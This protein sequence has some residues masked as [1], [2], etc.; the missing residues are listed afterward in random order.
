MNERRKMISCILALTVATG[1]ASSIPVFADTASTNTAAT[2][3]SHRLAGIDRYATAVAISQK[4]WG[5]SDTVILA[6][7]EDY[8]DALTSGPLAKKYD[9]PI[10]LTSKASINAATIAEIVR[11]QAKNIIIIGREGAV[12]LG[13]ANQL[14]KAG[15]SDVTRIGGINRYE[16]STLVAAKLNKPSAVVVVPG[17]DFPDA[18]SVSSIAS[19]L[20]YSII[21]SAKSGLSDS[22]KNYIATN[23]IKKAYIVG[24]TG[25]L[26]PAIE[27]QVTG[28][29]RLAGVNRYETNLAVLKAFEST[30]NYDN[31]FIATGNNFADALAGAALASKTSSPIILAGSSM[32]TNT[33]EYLASKENLNT[34]IL[35]LGGQA[36]ISDS[37]VKSAIDEKATIAVA[38]NYSSE[39]TYSDGDISGSVII[40]AAGIN[41]KNTTISGDLLIASTVG[42]GSV[43]LDNVTV[44]GK[45][46]INGG[47]VNSVE[48]HNMHS[49]SVELDKAT[50]ESVRVATDATSSIDT[51]LVSANG[52][53]DQTSASK[54]GSITVDNNSSVVLKGGFETVQVNGQ[55]STVK[56]V[57][58]SIATLYVNAKS[59]KT[60]VNVD[61]NSTVVNLNVNAAVTVSGTGSI[62][63]ANIGANGTTI[64]II[65]ANT[66][67][68]AG[69]STLVNG[70]TKDSTNSTVI[71]SV[72]DGGETPTPVTLA[73]SGASVINSTTVTFSSDVAP[74]TVT[75]NGK[76]TIAASYNAATKLETITV[77]SITSAE[78]ALVVNATGYTATTLNY[79]IPVGTYENLIVIGTIADLNAA[80]KAQADGQTWIINAGNYGLKPIN[81]YS[82]SSENQTG[83]YF[84]ITANNITIQGIGNPTLF[85]N[86]YTANGNWSTQNLI[87]IFGD[88][89]KISGLTLMNK[90]DGNKIIEVAGANSTIEDCIIKP[91]T[92]IDES[93]YDNITNAEDKEFAKQWGGSIYYNS[94]GNHVMKNVIINNSGISF[95]YSPAGTHINFENVNLIYNSNID[96]INSYKYSSGFNNSDCSIT[97]KPVVS[98]VVDKVDGF[99]KDRYEPTSFTFG[100]D[101]DILDAYKLGI[102]SKGS[103][104]ARDSSYTSNF[105][106]TQGKS[107]EVANTSKNTSWQVEAKIYIS[108]EMMAGEKPFRAELWLG[109]KNPTGDAV[110][111]YPIIGIGNVDKDN[112]YDSTN[113]A[114]IWRWWNSNGQGLWTNS[115][116]EGVAAPSKGWH[117]LKMKCNGDNKI[118]YYVDNIELAEYLYDE[119]GS[120]TYLS[121][122]M[123]QSYNYNNYEDYKVDGNKV[124]NYSFDAYFKDINYTID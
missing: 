1:M 103:S 63:N 82:A 117:T 116:N 56:V 7:G 45:I 86:E 30:F 3:A 14:T 104:I 25:V 98:Y 39:G 84:P 26:S 65:P 124:M 53:V 50:G 17:L 61:T 37:I 5:T 51:V 100:D 15:F 102:D 113:K 83:W 4:G 76:A 101:L 20:G 120:Q 62:T 99:V 66:S 77:P 46:I 19:K 71:K 2:Q 34:K 55:G 121:S 35:A 44:A 12:S 42:E 29:V 6:S 93:I 64:A 107:Y 38:K 97:G 31:V 75:W 72:P 24:G 106:N 94:P 69:V 28:P 54:K 109:T 80:I 88:N 119:T 58:A 96:F 22:A 11:L 105:Y 13:V 108:D 114:P 87:T 52:I 33:A 70:T 79:T 23:E 81:D 95:R 111:A 115:K 8:A 36:I 68:T 118:V 10:L 78:N 60:I 32:N 18:L 91:N 59:S 123:L 41:L 67:V 48:L 57:S 90:V 110:N 16:T 21:L 47:G 49:K 27:K 92:I 73:I 89:V 122:I 85:G 43:D 112:K 40:S 74:T 9:A